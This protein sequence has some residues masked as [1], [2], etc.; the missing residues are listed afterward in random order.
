MTVYPNTD[1]L[2]IRLGELDDL[3]RQGVGSLMVDH[4]C[5][6]ARE[7][8][9]HSLNPDWERL[10]V[11]ED[12]ERLIIWVAE[13]VSPDSDNS[14]VVGYCCSVLAEH[15]HNKDQLQLVNNAIFVSPTV[16]SKGVGGLLMRA[17]EDSAAEWAAD[18]VWHA[19][20]HSRLDRIL[21]SSSGYRPTITS[22]V[23]KESNG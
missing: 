8:G 3:R 15:M 14:E 1:E 22:Y 12:A 4:F 6:V 9:C 11:L 16:R 13:Y 7:S 19:P 17:T 20:A 18:M 2:I 21:S 10:Q 5:E 23:K